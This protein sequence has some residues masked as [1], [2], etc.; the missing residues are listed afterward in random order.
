MIIVAFPMC[1]TMLIRIRQFWFTS[2]FWGHRMQASFFG[3]TCEGSPQWAGIIADAN[4]LAGHPLGFLNR[5]LYAIGEE[6]D[7]FHD[8][9]FGS[10]AFNG[11]S[12]VPGYIATPGWD[13]TTA[14]EHPIWAH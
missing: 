7:L 13:L 4:Q 11:F 8:I 1:L 10:N 2:V 9:T 5:K 3:G 14:G 6:S 12:G